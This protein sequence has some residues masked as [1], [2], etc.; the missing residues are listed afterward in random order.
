MDRVA[1]DHPDVRTVRG[2]VRRRGG[3]GRRIAVP[4]DI[5]PPSGPIRVVLAGDVR[6]GAIDS[7]GDTRSL[8]GVYDSP[9]DARAPGNAPDRLRAWLTGHDRD[10]G[11]SVHLDEIRPGFLLGLRVPGDREHYPVLEPPKSSLDAIARSIEDG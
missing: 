2:R 7:N 3:A 6:F 4:E 11:D 9:T 1:S 10:V 8:T 5:L